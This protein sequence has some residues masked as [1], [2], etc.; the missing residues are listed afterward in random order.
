MFAV[1]VEQETD[2]HWIAEIPELPRVMSYGQTREEAVRKAQDLIA[3]KSLGVVMVQ[4][5][6]WNGLPFRVIP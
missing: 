5:S 4:L 6:S 2:G 1:E 3:A